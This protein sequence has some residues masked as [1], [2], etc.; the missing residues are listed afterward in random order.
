M[1]VVLFLALRFLREYRTQTALTVGAVAVGV[2]V[3]VFLSALISGLQTSLIERTLGTQA[4]VMVRPLEER[5]RP[6]APKDGDGKVRH[7]EQPAQRI[8]SIAEWQRVDRWIRADAEVAA[9]APSAMGSAFATRGN[10]NRPVVV[11]GVDPGRFDQVIPVGERMLRGAYRLDGA[12]TVIGKELAANLGVDVGDKL[13]VQTPEGADALLTIRGVFDLGNQQVNER[14]VLVPLRSG[15]T[16]LGLPGGANAIH[17]KVRRVFEADRVAQRLTEQTGLSSESWMQSNAQLLIGLRSQSSS[18]YTIQFF[19]FLAVAIGIASVLVVSVVQRT[20]EIGILRAMGTP[21]RRIAG[22]FV[23]QGGM[24]GFLGSLVGAA[25][26]AALS[27]LFARLAQNPDG[28]AT[29]PIELT[30]RLVVS[31]SALATL[32]GVLAAAFPARQAARLDPAEA[33]RHV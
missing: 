18:S 6:I 23:L 5:A 9:T 10:A 30:T 12:E 32:T 17:V 14:W 19:V 20:R 4:H 27:F 11:L 22:V 7:V 28:T 2:S 3:M 31:A 8:R 15:Q 16:L 25:L 21:R 29:F 24:V 1:P 26:G 33:I 13:R